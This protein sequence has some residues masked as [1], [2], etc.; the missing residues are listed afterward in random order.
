[1]SS[2]SGWARRTRATSRVTRG[3]GASAHGDLGLT[4]HLHG[5]DQGRQPHPLGL[6]GDGRALRFRDGHQIRGDQGQKSLAQVVDQITGQL[7]G[8]VSGR[9]QVSHGHQGPAHI[10]LGQRLHHLVELGEVVIDPL[11]GGHLIEDGKR[12]T[13]RAPAAPHGQVQR[14][15]G[16][17]EVGIPPHLAEQLLQGL[18]TEESE[19]EVLG[20][21]SDGG[22]DLLRVGGG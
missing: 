7:R 2:T 15:I 10:P 21:A 3:S 13:G 20:A 18:G 5:P 1:M 19:L 8:A 22:E 11:R 17:V 6:P 12:I 4:Q 9:G 14:L 16:N